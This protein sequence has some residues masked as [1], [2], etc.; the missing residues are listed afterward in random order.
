MLYFEEQNILRG[1]TSI[2][3]GFLISILV[4]VAALV[5]LGR[6][7]RRPFPQHSPRRRS[8]RT[9]EEQILRRSDAALALRRA[10]AA[11][12]AARRRRSQ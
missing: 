11:A 2:A 1:Y 8:A 6:E 12:K 5:R 10:G 3:P 7:S 9:Q 4:R